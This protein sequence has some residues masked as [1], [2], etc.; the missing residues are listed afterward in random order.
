MKFSRSIRWL[1]ISFITLILLLIGYQ[2]TLN[3]RRIPQVAVTSQMSLIHVGS[4]DSFAITADGTQAGRYIL[5]MVQ[6]NNRAA[7][8]KAIDLYNQIIPRENYGGEYTALRWFAQVFLMSDQEKQKALQDPFTASFYEFF[9]ENNFANLK[10]YVKRKYLLDQFADQL[11]E[12]GR[13]RAAFLEDFILFNNPA[14]EEWEKSSKILAVVPIAEG[15]TIADIGSGPGYYS[16]RFSKKVGATGRVYSIDLVQDHLDYINRYTKRQ[17]ITNITTINSY[18]GTTIGLDGKQVDVAFMCSL[19]HNIYGMS[20][21]PD[22]DSFVQSIKAALKPGGQ[23]VVVDNGLVEPGQLPYHGPY[24]AKELIIHQFHF[25]GF[26]LKKEYA[27][28]PQRYV[29][30]F[31]QA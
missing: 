30:I 20:T 16:T 1:V 26:K 13:N 10:E 2:I 4:N 21:A 29:L 24:V 8:Q 28:I 14:R 31:E 22:R 17:N 3:S 15:Q 7:A 27:F 23:L 5:E 12:A 6:N 9:A 11:T 18:P 25:Y 19:Y